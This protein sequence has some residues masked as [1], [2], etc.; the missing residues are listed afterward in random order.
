MRE[1]APQAARHSSSSSSSTSPFPQPQPSPPSARHSTETIDQF[2]ADTRKDP[3]A[4]RQ[5]PMKFCLSISA[6]FSLA[7]EQQAAGCARGGLTHVHT[8]RQET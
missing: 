8:Y 2:A 3:P 4:A 7:E 5:Q 6:A 1:E